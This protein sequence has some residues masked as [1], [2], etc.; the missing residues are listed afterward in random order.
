MWIAFLH[1]DFGNVGRIGA[2]VEF[3]GVVWSSWVE[4]RVLSFSSFGWE[5]VEFV[6]M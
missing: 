3:G 5:L 1:A 6:A 4:F 2:V